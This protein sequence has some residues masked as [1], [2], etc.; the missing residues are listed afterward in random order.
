MLED[1]FNHLLILDETDDLV[2]RTR[3]LVGDY[4][5]EGGLCIK[6]ISHNI[7]GLG[8]DVFEMSVEASIF[9]TGI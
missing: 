8:A 1:L 9:W 3:F 6:K 4:N 7:W 2:I 5:G